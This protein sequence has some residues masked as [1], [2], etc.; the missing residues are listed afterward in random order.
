[1]NSLFEND[2]FLI[3]PELFLSISTILLLLYGV[4]FSTKGSYPVLILSIAWLGVFCLVFTLLLQLN[5]PIHGASFFYNTL[6]IDDFTSYFKLIVIAGSIFSI[7]LS[8]NYILYLNGF[9]Y[10]I[11]I[12]LSIISMLLLI[13]SG[14]F[15][16]MYLAIEF[17]SLCFYVLAGW[18]RDSEFS[19]EAGLKYFL[20]GAFS[21]GLLLFGCSLIY[22]F[23]G[24]TNFAEF[25]LLGA[26][27]RGCELGIIFLLVGLLFKLTAVPFHMWSPDVYEG[28]PFSVTA[29]FAIVPKAAILAVAI[30]LCILMVD[31]SSGLIPWQKMIY[32]CSIAS[33]I[34]GAAAALSQKKIK[35]LLAW[36]SIGHV[37][38]LL[39]GL[40]CGTL[41][42]IQAIL[43]YLFI[44]IVT[45]ITIFALVLSPIRRD[46]SPVL[47][48]RVKY[49]TDLALLAQTN[50]LMAIT[51]AITLFSIAGIPPLAGF[52]SKALMFFAAL[53]STLY[54]VALVGILTSVVSCFYYIRLV[55][56]MYFEAPL[57]WCSFDR[58]PKENGIILGICLF[59]IIFFM[60]YPS[61]L[62]L[63][64]HKV[65]LALT[66]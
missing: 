12:L 22:G 41:Q 27:G 49:T 55:K 43:F 36:S 63:I 11:L 19:T 48:Q 66:F 20:L 7:L 2:F 15:I 3:F 57:H 4:S 24:V 28:A 14:D 6:V 23:T 50:P 40:T 17:Q 26:S 25:G 32:F 9:E 64:T 47:Q 56:I 18:K 35:R 44:Y 16:S 33:M 13:S 42:G 1:M 5:T 8:L 59:F 30:R 53:S 34:L 60:I 52:Y 21:S 65:A 45:S 51:L 31:S 46:S 61:P 58:M 62:Y 37:G 38:Y 10:I 29:F 54:T 39:I